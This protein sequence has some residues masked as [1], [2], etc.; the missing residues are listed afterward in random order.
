MSKKEAATAG[1]EQPSPWNLPNALTALR[2]VLVPVFLWLLWLNTPATRW[3]SLA[4][5]V[6][7]AY[8]D[9]LDG[10]IARKQGLITNFGKLADPLADK[11][12][13]LGAFV[14]L[15]L[16]G[17]LTWWFTAIVAIR[18]IGITILREVLRR[19]NVVVAASSGGKLKTVLQIFLIGWMIAPWPAFVPV[20][21]IW[22]QMV[23]VITWIL[24]IAALVV[25]V[26]SGVQYLVAAARGTASQEVASK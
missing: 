6:V 3:W 18:E 1:N 19:R 11:F 26:L 8:T 13:T 12:M 2:L 14:V 21:S 23:T 16:L 20:G 22:M 10:E 9:H 17:E 24:G 25:T 15:S 4:I 7:A 5:F